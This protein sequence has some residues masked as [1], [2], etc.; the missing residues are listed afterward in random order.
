MTPE[1]KEQMK[2]I[3]PEQKKEM[4]KLAHMGP[5]DKKNLQTFQE[6]IQG[7]I[8][9]KWVTAVMSLLKNKPEVFKTMFKGMGSMAGGEAADD[10]QVDPYIDFIV[11]MGECKYD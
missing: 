7:A 4:M 2:N 3:T 5:R 11:G 10:S 6:G 1:Q 9:E 8:D